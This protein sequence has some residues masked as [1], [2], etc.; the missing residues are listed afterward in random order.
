[1]TR[2]LILAMLAS[3]DPA[4]VDF[5]DELVVLVSTK[6]GVRWLAR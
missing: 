5:D 6:E 1:M 4:F 3:T 2:A